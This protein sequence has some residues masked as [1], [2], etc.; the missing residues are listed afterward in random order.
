[1][2]NIN[3]LSIEITSTSDSAVK[4]MDNLINKLE[5]LD[6]KANSFKGLDNYTKKIENLTK[7]IAKIDANIAS[8][9]KSMAEAIKS[10]SDVRISK[11][12]NEKF[13]SLI[14]SLNNADFSKYGQLGEM[15]EPLSQFQTLRAGSMGTLA[16]HVDSLIESTN[17]IQTI[18][19]EAISNQIYSLKNAIASLSDMPDTKNFRSVSN[20]ISKITETLPRLNNINLKSETVVMIKQLVETLKPLESVSKADGFKNVT[21]GLDKLTKVIG[22]L[23][24]A[25][26]DGFN[27]DIQRLTEI[28]KPLAN[29]MAKVNSGFERFPQKVRTM[30]LATQQFTGTTVTASKVGKLIDFTAIYYGVTRTISGI[31]KFLNESNRYVEDLNLFNASL[32]RFSR[33]AQNYAEHVSEIMGIDPAE[34][35]R[36]QG[37]FVSLAKGFGILDEKAVYMSKNL[38][39]LGYDIASFFNIS[40]N[41]AM[42]KVQSGLAGELEPMRRIG[43]DLSVARMKTD[44]L[45]LGIDK[46][47]SA[48]TQAEKASLRYYAM[49]T[50]VTHVQ[51][52][53]ARTLNAPANQLRVLSA[54]FTLLTRS[55]GNLFI[56][57]LNAVLPYIITVTKALRHLIDLL[58]KALGFKLPEIDYSGIS[59]PPAVIEDMDNAVGNIG[60]GFN[61]ANKEAEKFKATV[62][63]FDELN[64]LNEPNSRNNVGSGAG[65]LGDLGN[66]GVGALD[67]E[68]PGYDFLKDQ[69]NSRISQIE[70]RLKPFFKWVED[71]F[72]TIKKAVETIG[73][74]LLAWKISTKV[75]DWLNGDSI[76]TKLKKLYNNYKIAIG[77]TLGVASLKIAWDTWKSIGR[78]GWSIGNVVK[79]IGSLIG[80]SYA[81]FMIGGVPGLVISAGLYVAVSTIALKK[82]KVERYIKDWFG[83]LDLSDEEISIMVDN[84][85]A[86]ANIKK[87]K[88]L[89][90]QS[91]VVNDLQNQ[92]QST[93]DEIDK[94]EYQVALGLD[95]DSSEY[96][97]KI[98][99]FID[100]GE[101]FIKEKSI[102]LKLSIDLFA[103]DENSAL[104][105]TGNEIFER[106][107]VLGER[108]SELGTEYRNKLNEA[109]NKD[110]VIDIDVIKSAEEI[111]KQM[112][113]I[114]DIVAGA[115]FRGKQRN[116][117]MD[118]KMQDL[119][120]E[121]FQKLQTA[122]ND[123][124]AKT[125]EDLRK[126]K[127]DLEIQI[128]AH[129]DLMLKEPNV[130]KNQVEIDRAKALQELNES[131]NAKEFEI[132]M[133]NSKVT[134]DEITRKVEEEFGRIEPEVEGTIEDFIKG[135]DYYLHADFETVKNNLGDYT[136]DIAGEVGNMFENMGRELEPEARKAIKTILDGMS[137][138]Y[139]DDIENI[140]GYIEEGKKVPQSL[141]D[142]VSDRAKLEALTGSTEG[143]YVVMDAVLKDSKTLQSLF[144]SGQISMQELIQYMTTGLIEGKE[145]LLM[146]I[147][148]ITDDVDKELTNN[149]NNTSN[150]AGEWS[151]NTSNNIV[152]NWQTPNLPVNVNY[153]ENIIRNPAMAGVLSRYPRQF[154]TGGFPTT[155][156]VFIAREAG[157]EMVGSIGG[158][159]AVANNDQIV[160]A[161]SQGVAKAV[162]SVMGGN[163][164]DIVVQ[165]KNPNEVTAREVGRVNI[166]KAR[167]E[168]V[169]V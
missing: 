152:A 68:L 121:S 169:R 161:V 168:G 87:L 64:I 20:T 18:G 148:R 36:N 43:Y 116:I 106:Y 131:Y 159:T 81:G 33:E 70:K 128:E 109:I 160:T 30:N 24:S 56:P 4:A 15:I 108:F 46:Q 99:Q 66:G 105:Q 74:A 73:L 60:K 123:M 63:A 29:E 143:L 154:A 132:K 12:F 96:Q 83:N 34:W 62:L 53:M 76:A 102:D 110:G 40:V 141:I 80:A 72:D 126:K 125:I 79:A 136:R 86:T 39:Q 150:T 134:L 41:D 57:I 19:G 118:Y 127:E 117:I 92:V 137:P 124:E 7:G 16:K 28:L 50:Q 97:A 158:R 101:A 77:I 155:G 88:L 44:A 89:M 47:V 67:I 75:M 103:T 104:S 139:Y 6:V 61:N 140:K 45:T 85:Y 151:R 32:G 163:T 51:G 95:Y 3:E 52:D 156:E 90:N 120:S 129:Y 133:T 1:M 2:S 22:K 113:E 69:V 9:I 166:S 167:R 55:I 130:D 11:D 14:T 119:S 27:K 112:V 162:S 114:L 31:T 153:L 65:G 84:I 164:G 35:L 142:G 10:L 42:R 94:L 54:Q 38:T 91:E 82:G 78:D 8:K 144:D 21:N 149:L 165:I 122:L 26:L 93:I 48:M 135:M 107:S 49:M 145:D 17:K 138:K 147:G 146:Q 13:N 98:N 157:A 25:D 37:L 58:G 115:E 100:E 111:K 71:N 23:R 5:Q 59:S